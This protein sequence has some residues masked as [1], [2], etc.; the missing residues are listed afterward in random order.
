[1]QYI[2]IEFEFPG[3]EQG[4]QEVFGGVVQRITNMSGAT[5]P[6]TG[7]YAVLDANPVQP[8]WA[9]PDPPVVVANDVH[10]LLTPLAFRDRF[11]LAEKAAIYTAAKQNVLIQ[12]WLDD[13]A[14]A[15]EVDLNNQS[16]AGGVHALEQAGLLAPNRAAEILGHA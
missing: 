16:L 1:M 10:T 9:L 8:A 5:R 11:T 6:A 7:S 13:L 12:S 3:G 14:V 2:L 15:S 4:Y